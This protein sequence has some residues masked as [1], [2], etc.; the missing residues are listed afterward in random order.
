MLSVIYNYSIYSDPSLNI[1]YEI[2]I[3][4]FLIIVQILDPIVFI[5]LCFIPHRAIRI[6]N[7]NILFSALK[8]KKES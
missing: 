4:T 8:G 1:P 6:T 7:D 5:K 2:H 3:L